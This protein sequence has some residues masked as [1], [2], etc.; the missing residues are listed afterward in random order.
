MQGKSRLH[1][2]ASVH[3]RDSSCPRRLT[4]RFSYEILIVAHVTILDERF[5]CVSA[6]M[7][8]LIARQAE[9]LLS[10]VGLHSFPV[11]NCQLARRRVCP[12]ISRID[13]YYIDRYLPF[14]L[15]FYCSVVVVT[16]KPSSIIHHSD[17]H[18]SLPSVIVN[19]VWKFYFT[20]EKK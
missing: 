15:L 4:P 20:R 6:R 9:T 8:A 12:A 13:P 7:I 11:T 1:A 3:P 16:M 5:A 2:S 14:P 19:A 18:L 17:T 10:R